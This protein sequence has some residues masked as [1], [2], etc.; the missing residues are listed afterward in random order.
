MLA[1]GYSDVGPGYDF[2][3][4][5]AIGIDPEDA[6]TFIHSEKPSYPEFEKWIATYPGVKLDAA[7][8]DA[9]NA[10]II[11]Y[12]HTDPIRQSILSASGIPDDGSILDAIN[13]NNL[14]D[15]N[16]THAA[17]KGS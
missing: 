13:L 10:A 3:L 16:A 11:G 17:L 14:D 1:D 4:L 9:V 6:R 2:M 5:E 7:T 8:I 15:W 12:N